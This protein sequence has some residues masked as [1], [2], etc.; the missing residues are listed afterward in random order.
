MI[1]IAKGLVEQHGDTLKDASWERFKSEAEKAM[2]EWIT[3]SLDRINISFDVFFNENSLYEDKSV[4]NTLEILENNGH[5]YRSV[6][7]E[8]AG[9]VRARQ[10]PRRRTGSGLVSFDLVWRRRRSRAG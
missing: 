8:G 3:R 6:I 4:W 9:R 1:D 10:V 7:R 5:V 2:F